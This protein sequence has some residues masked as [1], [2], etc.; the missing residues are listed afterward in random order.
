MIYN[1]KSPVIQGFFY[2]INNVQC[3][4]Y[5]GTEYTPQVKGK[6]PF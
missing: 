2:C 6:P 5:T 3:I 1:R 4:N